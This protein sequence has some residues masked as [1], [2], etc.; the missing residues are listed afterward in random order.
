LK[1]EIW[2][3]V[4]P[5]DLS[6]T[7]SEAEKIVK[8]LSKRWRVELEPADKLLILDVERKENI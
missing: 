3:L 4:K 2:V 7:R 5:H 1:K 6:Y 8:N